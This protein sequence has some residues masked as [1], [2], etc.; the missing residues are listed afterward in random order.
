MASGVEARAPRT[1]PEPIRCGLQ[2]ASFNNDPLTRRPVDPSTWRTALY[3]QLRDALLE[4]HQLGQLSKNEI[5]AT[6]NE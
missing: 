1:R 2:P 6:L 4:A 3:D 5:T